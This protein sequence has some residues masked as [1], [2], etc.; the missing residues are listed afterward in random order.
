MAIKNIIII[1]IIIIILLVSIY[2]RIYYIPNLYYLLQMLILEKYSEC[3]LKQL[4]F[5]HSSICSNITKN[6]KHQNALSNNLSI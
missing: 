6:D 2:M 3:I 1:I 4:I 5:L